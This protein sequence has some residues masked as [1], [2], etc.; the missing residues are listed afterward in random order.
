MPDAEGSTPAEGRVIT[1]P[2][3]DRMMT[4]KNLKKRVLSENSGAP[5]ATEIAIKLAK[6]HDIDLAEV[7]GSG[8]D[9]R[10]LKSDIEKLI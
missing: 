3:H 4:V 1:G 8:A 9:G 6:E 10:I 7:S 5:D 2:P